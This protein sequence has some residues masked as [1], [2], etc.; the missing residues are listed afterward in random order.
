MLQRPVVEE[1]TQPCSKPQPPPEPRQSQENIEP[2]IRTITIP[3]TSPIQR[4]E[5]QLNQDHTIPVSTDNVHCHTAPVF[6]PAQFP[7]L[8]R[9]REPINNPIQINQ[10]STNNGTSNISPG[11]TN[12]SSSFFDIET[13]AS[14]ETQIPYSDI[15]LSILSPHQPPYEPINH[16]SGSSDPAMRARL[17]RLEQRRS[18]FPHVDMFVEYTEERYRRFRP[19]DSQHNNEAIITGNHPYQSDKYESGTKPESSF[20]YRFTSW[21]K[22]PEQQQHQTPDLENQISPVLEGSSTQPHVKHLNLKPN[23]SRSIIIPSPSTITTEP[24]LTSAPVYTPKAIPINEYP[25]N[26]EK[27]PGDDDLRR[28]QIINS[29]DDEVRDLIDGVDNFIVECFAGIWSVMTAIGDF[30]VTL[31]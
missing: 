24:G 17:D 26:F 22:K 19:S 13:S 31:Y 15:E 14:Q 23:T 4:Q 20:F 6:K 25:L 8:G 5:N 9:I 2:E 7:L 27:L 16:P 29:L 30:F 18:M 21:R 3:S 11:F 1:L 12:S 28:T 10:V